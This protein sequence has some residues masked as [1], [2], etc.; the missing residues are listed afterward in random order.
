VSLEGPP[1]P[2]ASREGLARKYSFVC[3]VLFCVFCFLRFILCEAFRVCFVLICKF[4]DVKRM[5][6]VVFIRTP[7]LRGNGTDSYAPVPTRSLVRKTVPSSART[8]VPSSVRYTEPPTPAPVKKQRKNIYRETGTATHLAPEIVYPGFAEH[9]KHYLRDARINRRT[10]ALMWP[11]P[12]PGIIPVLL[13]G[14]WRGRACVRIRRSR[15]YIIRCHE[16][17]SQHK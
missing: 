5:V 1:P 17:M 13:D 14:G 10:E 4:R 6:S 11:C 15:E 8:T 7:T 16:R 9:A 12:F 2:K 3:L